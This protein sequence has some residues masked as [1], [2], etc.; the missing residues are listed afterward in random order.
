M[1]SRPWAEEY[2]TFFICVDSY[3]QGVMQGRIYNP[4]LNEGRHFQSLTGF[5]LEMEQALDEMDF[6]KAYTTTRTFRK[7]P[8]KPSE[9]PGP[10]YPE[11]D[12]ATFSVRI[13]FRQNA[14]WQGSVTWLDEKQEQSFRSV[15]ELILLFDN[16][17]TQ[18]HAS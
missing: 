18:K 8:E 12:S 16:A 11:G 10:A 9:P 7:P 14:S 15:L 13:L 4:Q 3:R 17:L 2:R 6:P 5:L 1:I